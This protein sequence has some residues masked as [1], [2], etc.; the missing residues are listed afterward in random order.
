[1]I[2]K[3]CMICKKKFQ[4]YPNRKKIAKFCS[5]S[6]KAKIFGFKKGHPIYLLKHTKKTKKHISK[7]KTGQHWTRERRIK[8]CG[9]NTSGWKG[10][11]SSENEI[12]RKRLEYKLWREAV[13]ARDNWICQKC[14]IRN[15]LGLG[16]TIYLHSHHIFNFVKY[17]ELR[18][19]IDNGITFC[20]DCHKEFHKKYGNKNNKEQIKEFLKGQTHL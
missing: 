3:I 12:M 19:V 4:I 6:C 16:K 9:K 5:Y 15:Y 18:F 14:K 10:G 20:R 8:F 7:T 1:M 11:V 13:F 2:T 17:P